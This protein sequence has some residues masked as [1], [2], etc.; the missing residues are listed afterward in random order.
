MSEVSRPGVPVRSPDWRPG[1]K[2]RGSW[3]PPPAAFEGVSSRRA[4]AYL[5]DVFVIA[6]LYIPFGVA[7][8]LLGLL[9]FGLL[10]GPAFAL[11]ALLPLA[12]HVCLIGGPGSATLG[13]RWMDVE[14]RTWDGNPPGFVQAAVQTVLFYLSVG[15]LTP[16]ILLVALFN[17]QA[18][19]L[20]DYLCGAVV[21]RTGR[22]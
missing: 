18:R 20:H 16:L 8:G 4:V 22:G 7:A 12:Y 17:D 6:L 11:L 2:D 9:S 15:V 19:C 3:S 14:V 1:R 10:F 13:M 21:I 5:I